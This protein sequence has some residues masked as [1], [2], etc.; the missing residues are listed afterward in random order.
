MISKHSNQ[1]KEDNSTKVGCGEKI[2]VEILQEKLPE[3]VIYTQVHLNYLV[4]K[5]ETLQFSER[6]VKETIDVLLLHKNRFIIFRVQHGSNCKY[7]SKGHLWDKLS[8]SDSIQ[9]RL[10]QRYHG[11]YSVIDLRESECK[12]LFSNI[13]NWYSQSEVGIQC[14]LEGLRL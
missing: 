6:Q 8:Q 9:K 2:L 1:I 3:C 5:E 10:V 11:K 12:V 13:N 14:E 7:R 4:P